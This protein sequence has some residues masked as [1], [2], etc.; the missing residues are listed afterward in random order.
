MRAFEVVLL[1]ADAVMLALLM[2]SPQRSR[3]GHLALVPIAAAI[4]QL[5]MEGA[6]WQLVPAYALG[7]VLFAALLVRAVR[8]AGGTGSKDAAEPVGAGS[9]GG[10][11]RVRRVVVAGLGLVVMGG[12]VAVPLAVPVFRFPEPTGPF[13]IGTLTYHWVDEARAEIFTADPGDRRELM[14]QIR[15]PAEA[16]PS[17]PR[18]PYLEN[19]EAVT[20]ALGRVLQVPGFVLGHL[21]YVTTNA[22]RSAPAL[23]GRYPVLVFLAGRMGLRQVNTFQIEELASRGYVI[24]ALDQPYAAARVIFPDG[25]ASDYDP[26]MN[27]RAFKVAHI[28]HLA[29]DV[30]FA[31]NR[32][33]DIDRNDSRLQG[34]LD[35]GLAG[36]FGHSLG[37]VVGAQAC[38]MEPRLRACLLEDAFMPDEVVR[39]GLRQPTMWITRDAATM[40]L[41]RHRAGDWPETEIEEHHRTMRAVFETLP[42]EGHFVQVPGMLHLDMTDGPLLAPPLLDR[43]SDQFPEVLL[44][45]TRK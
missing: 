9:A 32:L 17:A 25:R 20:P 22:V 24:V 29:R 43:P 8:P 26:R 35:L 40:R 28:P 36:L 18:T 13:A 10:R 16:D 30:T 39:T 33:V 45:S 11:R 6:R 1:V 27:N 14:A 4:V 37:G 7:V 44:E 5:L 15:Y 2:I 3:C 23:P 21:R 38:M 12:A 42:G 19:A 31:L 34:R 41:E